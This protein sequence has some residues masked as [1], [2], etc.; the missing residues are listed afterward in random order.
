MWTTSPKRAPHRQSILHLQR[1]GSLQRHRRQR[2]R[3]QACL[4]HTRQFFRVMFRAVATQ[5][6]CLL[7][8]HHGLQRQS[9]MHPMTCE[10]SI[11]ILRVSDTRAPVPT[12]SA[13]SSHARC[14]GVSTLPQKQPMVPTKTCPQHTQH[15]DDETKTDTLN[16]DATAAHLVSHSEIHIR[17]ETKCQSQGGTQ[18]GCITAIPTLATPLSAALSRITPTNTCQPQGATALEPD[19]RTRL[20]LRILFPML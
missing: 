20:L 7:L 1:S 12:S 9:R 16:T 10:P 11:L 15:G 3:G 2:T 14:T 4:R 8:R 5:C 6:R 13:T 18:V 17:D 19:Y